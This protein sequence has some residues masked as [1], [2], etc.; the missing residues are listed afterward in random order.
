METEGEKIIGSCS[1]AESNKKNYTKYVYQPV[2]VTDLSE[3]CSVE[4]L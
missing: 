4:S 2:C 1:G 3:V